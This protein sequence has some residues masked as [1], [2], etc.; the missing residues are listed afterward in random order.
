MTHRCQKCERSWGGLR[1]EHCRVCHETFSGTTAGDRHRVGV[2]E[3]PVLPAGR[4]CLSVAEMTAKGLV[5]NTH[6]IWTS[7]GENP[8]VTTTGGAA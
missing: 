3:T 1:A 5:Q 2:Y 4:R 8:W 6:G 7:G